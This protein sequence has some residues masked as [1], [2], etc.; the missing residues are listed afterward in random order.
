MTPKSWTTSLDLRTSWKRVRLFSTFWPKTS[1]FLTFSRDTKTTHFWKKSLVNDD[2]Y[3]FLTIFLPKIRCTERNSR[4]LTPFLTLFS[5]PQVMT[6]L[7]ENDPKKGSK[8]PRLFLIGFPLFVLY[9]YSILEGTSPPE[10]SLFE[11]TILT[12]FLVKNDDFSS[13][14]PNFR[15][16]KTG[17]LHPLGNTHINGKRSKKAVV[18]AI[19]TPFL[20]YFWPQNLVEKRSR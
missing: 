18:F 8:K 7:M 13:R 2:F 17:F 19:F 6:I 16:S 4:F 1:E 12:P 14:W 15:T 9:T 3:P 5:T 20:A 10:G 11:D